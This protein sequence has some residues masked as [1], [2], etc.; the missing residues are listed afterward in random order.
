MII[1]KIKKQNKHNQRNMLKQIIFSKYSHTSTNKT[2][3]NRVLCK[4][5][6]LDNN[7]NSSDELFNFGELIKENNKT[8]KFK[9]TCLKKQHFLFYNSVKILCT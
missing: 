2:F 1:Y 7:I 5:K 8:N 4:A 9:E 6:N 3:Q